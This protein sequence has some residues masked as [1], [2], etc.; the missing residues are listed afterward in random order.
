MQELDEVLVMIDLEYLG[1]DEPNAQ[2]LDI[3]ICYGT[4]PEN[5]QR[6][7]YKPA[8]QSG[9]AVQPS[10]LKFWAELN[11]VKL[12]SYMDNKQPIRWVTEDLYEELIAISGF[13]KDL[14]KPVVFM[15]KGITHDL[16]KLEHHLDKVFP[17][18]ANNGMGIFES[19]FGYNCRR[20][21][22]SFKMYRNPSTVEI[23]KNLGKDAANT[24]CSGETL[25]DAEWDAVSQ[26]HEVYHLAIRA[27]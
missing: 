24:L 10:T 17:G 20:D 13:A 18:L 2:I 16:P 15:S 5:L 27:R 12:A 1:K 22:R 23:A 4:S 3:G 19:M 7:S 9:G 8:W 11:A 25:H 14:G 6:V 21:M 26:W